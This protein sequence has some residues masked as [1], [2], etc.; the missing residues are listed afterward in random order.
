M[1]KNVKD[2]KKLLVKTAILDAAKDIVRLDG[3]KSLSIRK[4]ADQ[5]D[6]SVGSIYQYYK[7]KDDIVKELIKV[8]YK[9]MLDILKN[10]KPTNHL[11]NDIKNKFIAY[12]TFALNNKD[13]Y[14]E[15]MLSKDPN[16]LSMTRILDGDPTPGMLM[17]VNYLER[18]NKDSDFSIN[19]PLDTAKFLWSSVFGLM[20]KM[21]IEDV[22]DMNL[23]ENHIDLLMN[24]LKGTKQ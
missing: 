12:S 11:V 16:V 24:T 4:I 23:V 2:S 19:N 13:Y 10:Q 6:Y 18:L 21:M 7:N 15:M 14:K 22:D 8:K 20:I 1:K 17:L 3:F 9:E 5:I